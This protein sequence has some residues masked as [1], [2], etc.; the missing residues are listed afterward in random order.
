MDTTLGTVVRAMGSVLLGFG[1][2]SVANGALFALIGLR[3]SAGGVPSTTIGLVMS[4]Y[5]VGLLA[6]SLSSDHI[7]TASAIS[8]PSPCSPQPPA[9]RCCSWR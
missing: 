7:I 4:A 1:L 2:L 3:L 6:G 9:S 8:A 5:F